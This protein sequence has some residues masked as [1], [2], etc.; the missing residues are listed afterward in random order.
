[1]IKTEKLKIINNENNRMNIS[2][3]KKTT[4]LNDSQILEIQ[5]KKFM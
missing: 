4:Q 2:Y 1:M 3:I 5:K